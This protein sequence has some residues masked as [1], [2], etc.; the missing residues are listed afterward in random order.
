MEDRDTF[1][2]YSLI[3]AVNWSSLKHM[4]RSPLHYQHALT[5]DREDSTA[6]AMGRATHT[7]VL[8]PH[9]L[10][11]DYAVFGGLRRAGKEWEAFEAANAGKTILKREE[12]QRCIAMRDAVRAHPVAASYLASGQAEK[13]ITWKHPGV[14]LE[15][16]GRLD[17]VSESRA[18]VVDLKTTG[19]VDA[20][21]FASL[22]A[23]MGYFKQLAFYR[24]GLAYATGNVLAAVIIA[25]EAK[26]PHD[27]AV[28]PIDEDSLYAAAEQYAE[29]LAKVA[30]CR[31]SGV[32]P[33]RYPEEQPLRMPA[34]N[35]N[36]EE[37]ASGLDLVIGGHSVSSEP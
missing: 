18:A 35:W 37:D 7:A 33:G 13:T 15:C 5:A 28:L 32:W 30:A 22:A 14:G 36:D 8:E 24:D 9:R 16:K 6:M 3:D 31:Q 12:Y 19:D 29:L 11:T 27:V 20:V 23:R 1:A 21:K 34:W 10:E 4:E 2:T 26:A 17:W 25:V